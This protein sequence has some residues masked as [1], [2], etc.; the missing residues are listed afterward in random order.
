MA[1]ADGHKVVICQ[2]PD[3]VPDGDLLLLHLDCSIIPEQ[4]LEAAK[5]F[6]VAINGT[7]SNIC[8]TNIS[9]RLLERN[10]EWAG[11]VFVKSN[12]NSYG[13]PEESQNRRARHLKQPEPYP[14]HIVAKSYAHYASMVDVPADV[15]LAPEL[16]VEKF[17]D[18][19]AKDGFVM[20]TYFFCGDQERCAMH[21]SPLLEVKGADVIRSEPAKVPDEIRALREQMGFDFGKFDF[22][23]HDNVPVLLD[24]NKTPG[25][26]NT[27]PV[28]EAR[29]ETLAAEMYLGLIRSLP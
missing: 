22:V 10:S 2:N 3:K 9:S 6:P 16:I 19:R 14:A 4:Y 29:I 12:L 28:I 15:W 7:V 5:K 18:E 24:A 25:N 21:V 8:K 1:R 27:S 20:R 17:T 11:A 26:F 13:F 23:I